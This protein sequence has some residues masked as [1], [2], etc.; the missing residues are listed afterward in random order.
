MK[1]REK[2]ENNSMEEKKKPQEKKEEPEK[3]KPKPKTI[4]EKYQDSLKEI[5]ELKKNRM[6]LQAEMENSQKIALKRIENSKY[7]IKVNVIRNFL[8]IVDSFEAAI[9]KYQASSKKD[10]D[11]LLDGIKSLE[12]QFLQVLKGLGIKPIEQLYVPFNYKEHDVF[13]KLVDEGQP[14]D[15]VIKIAQKGYYLGE[16]VLRPAKVIVSKKKDKPKDAILVEAEDVD[17][18]EIAENDK[19]AH[20]EENPDVESDNVKTDEPTKTDYIS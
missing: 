2:K 9:S 10:Y 18:K 7:D 19:E 3:P 5:D 13:M 1:K 11:Q 16:N 8:P 6:Y 14:E 12:K 4:E 15:T 17:V 20:S